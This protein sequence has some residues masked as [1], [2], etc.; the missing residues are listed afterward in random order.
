MSVWQMAIM[1]GKG[2]FLGAV[3]LTM[4]LQKNSSLPGNKSHTRCFCG[5]DTLQRDSQEH[6][7]KTA[8]CEVDCMLDYFWMTGSSCY[9]VFVHDMLGITAINTHHMGEN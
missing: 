5:L 8:H 3:E 7:I 2:R 6:L 4:A 9:W 1:R